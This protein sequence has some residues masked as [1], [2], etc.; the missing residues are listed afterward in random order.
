[1]SEQNFEGVSVTTMTRHMAS[2]ER[3]MG[4]RSCL[5]ACQISKHNDGQKY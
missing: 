1:M 2:I 5:P 3:R 4:W